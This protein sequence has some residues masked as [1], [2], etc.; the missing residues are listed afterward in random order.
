MSTTI[1]MKQD[2]HISNF[3][4]PNNKLEFGSKSIN[5]QGVKIW[6]NIPLSVKNSNNIHSFKHCF[7]DVLIM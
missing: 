3:E 1:I 6:N 7:K 5:Y 2:I 4:F